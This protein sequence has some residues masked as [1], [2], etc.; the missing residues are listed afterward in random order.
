VWLAFLVTIVLALPLVR[1][2][3]LSNE[4][5]AIAYSP[6]HLRLRRGRLPPELL[7]DLGDVLERSKARRV[8]VRVVVESGQPRVRSQGD[9]APAIEQQLRNVV[10]RFPVARIRAGSRRA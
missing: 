7:R 6:G 5:F 9:L 3:L 2:I 4:L 1:A 10:G 8:K